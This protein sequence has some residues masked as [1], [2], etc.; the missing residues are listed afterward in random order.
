MKNAC[1]ENWFISHTYWMAVSGLLT[2]PKQ[3]K[4][5]L[6]QNKYGFISVLFFTTHLRILTFKPPQ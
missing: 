2:L 1:Q 5:C 6:K 4:I 3:Q